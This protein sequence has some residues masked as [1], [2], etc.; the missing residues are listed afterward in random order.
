[1]RAQNP[2]RGMDEEEGGCMSPKEY[3]RILQA[4]HDEAVCSDTRK[5]FARNGNRCTILISTYDDGEC[6]FCKERR[7]NELYRLNGKVV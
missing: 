4:Y 5:C 1:M 6:P 2:G 7:D 3:E